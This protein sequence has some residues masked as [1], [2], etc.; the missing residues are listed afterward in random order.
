[1]S[2]VH[3][4]ITAD[5]AHRI[6]GIGYELATND[7]INPCVCEGGSQGD[8]LSLR[9]RSRFDDRS[10]YRGCQGFACPRACNVVWCLTAR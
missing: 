3:L 9:L 8:V 1:M 7:S 6:P 10:N 5:V 4:G 2:T